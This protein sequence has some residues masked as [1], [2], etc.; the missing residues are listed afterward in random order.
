MISNYFEKNHLFYV[1]INPDQ[2]KNIRI[3]SHLNNPDIKRYNSYVKYHNYTRPIEEFYQSAEKIFKVIQ[4]CDTRIVDFQGDLLFKSKEWGQLC[5]IVKEV[6]Q[7]GNKNIP[8]LRK[9]SNGFNAHPGNHLAFAMLFLGIP[10]RCF[11]TTTNAWKHHVTKIST[12]H[13]TIWNLTQ[14]K[15]ILK[16]RDIEYWIADLDGQLVP[17]IYPKIKG[18]S[19]WKSYQNGDC[20]WPWEEVEQYNQDPVKEFDLDSVVP[21]RKFI[22]ETI[23]KNNKFAFLLTGKSEDDNF[24]KQSA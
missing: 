9:T 12:I 19:S 10:M 4:Y 13:E 14:I 11:F 5:S 2:H 24:F 23:M 16:T 3:L 15:K 17:H 21:K 7:N 6:Y 8:I 20:D 1:T 18:K 22:N